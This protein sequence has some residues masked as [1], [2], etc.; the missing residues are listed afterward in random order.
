MGGVGPHALGLQRAQQL[1]QQQRVPRGGSE[2]CRRE[3]RVR[4]AEPAPHHLG[5]AGGAQRRRPHTYG[6][7]VRAQLVEQLLVGVLLAGAQGRDQ[8]HRQPVQAAREV[9]QEPQ[10]RGVAP[11]HVV[12]RDHQR[13]VGAQVADDPV[14]PVQDREQALR[15]TGARRAG[16]RDV[17]HRRGTG[18]RAGEQPLAALRVG[19]HRVEQLPGDAEAELLLQRASP[20]A[21]HGRTGCVS[22]VA[23]QRQQ[24]G[25]A[26]AGRSLDD[27]GAGLAG[28]HV[29]QAGA[30]L[31]EL[32]LAVDEASAGGGPALLRH[33]DRA[34]GSALARRRGRPGAM[35]RCVEGRGLGQDLGLQ[36][37]QHGA[38]VDAELLGEPLAGPPQRRQRV[39][40]AV[41]AVE[42]ERQQP[43][44]L[45]AQRLLGEQ[46]L[47][48]RHHH[49]GLAAVEPARAQL[50]AGHRPELV[51]ASRLRVGPLRAG[52]VG[53]RRPPPQRE[54]LAQ[55]AHPGRGVLGVGGVLDETLEAPR[56][57][58]V[59]RPVVHPVLR[60]VV[61]G[62]GDAVAG[63]RAD[64]HPAGGPCGTVGLQRAAQVGDVG[65]Q[66]GGTA[67]RRAALPE[68]VEQ[69]LGADLVTPREHQHGNDRALA[70]A[71]E[72]HLVSVDARHERTEQAELQP[73]PRAGLTR[74]GHAVSARRWTRHDPR[75]EP[76]AR[77]GVSAKSPP[78]ELVPPV[79]TGDPGD[80][81]THMTHMTQ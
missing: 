10:R 42:R 75:A 14:Q 60:P 77:G 4:V 1:A 19:Q 32:A 59:V 51:E 41:R 25:L 27:R 18:R 73:R 64:Q 67:R 13:A 31:G 57:H 22:L 3:R 15:V 33:R 5:G 21:E 79:G 56:V 36:G 38:G 26:D 16:V 39:A 49:G 70:A 71:A 17:E 7:R 81:A 48:L 55:R 66:A 61:P 65:L 34:V 74:E 63:P 80:P 44:P 8:Q 37:T 12:D 76:A 58:P 43:P 6:V 2:A 28:Q 30:Q 29:G 9:A 40:L 20:G 23:H 69:P 47:R 78:L 11:L 62:D 46:G 54:R 53:Q 35:D 72:A 50:L 45:L 24:A 68:G 52:E